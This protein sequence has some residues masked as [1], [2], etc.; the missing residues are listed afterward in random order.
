M[1]VLSAGKHTHPSQGACAMEY[2]SILAGEEFTDRPECT[3][4]SFAFLAREINDALGDNSRQ[5]LLPIIPRLIGTKTDD[6]RV[7][8]GIAG[9]F[10]KMV[11]EIEALPPSVAEAIVEIWDVLNA[12]AEGGD[13]PAGWASQAASVLHALLPTSGK[14][15]IQLKYATYFALRGFEP[16]SVPFFDT[17]ESG[18]ECQSNAIRSVVHG[19]VSLDFD[20]DLY[21]DFLE[22]ILT[23]GLDRFEELSGRVV[24]ALDREVWREV[25]ELVGVS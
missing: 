18:V 7:L 19:Y 13:V 4:D 2:V 25:G 23:A 16:L 22:R 24:S 11:L 5:R 10:V 9:T 1:P 14:V 8:V 6:P 17:E 15:Q 12:W 20:E 21:A 3:L